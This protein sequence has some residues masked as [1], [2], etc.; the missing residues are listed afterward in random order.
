MYRAGRINAT[1]AAIG[2]KKVSFSRAVLTARTEKRENV[3]SVGK[4]KRR[5]GRE[6]CR[7]WF[8]SSQSRYVQ[9]VSPDPPIFVIYPEMK[10]TE[11]KFSAFKTLPLY[12]LCQDN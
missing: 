12:F 2:R 8:G 4:K 11:V 6:E 9:C 7:V 10:A 5:R 3:C 1:H